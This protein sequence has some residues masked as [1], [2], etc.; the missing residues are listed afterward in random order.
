MEE[1]TEVV[2]F[3]FV[4]KPVKIVWIQRDGTVVRE[5]IVRAEDK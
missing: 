5:A 4:D 3:A 2:V 1:P